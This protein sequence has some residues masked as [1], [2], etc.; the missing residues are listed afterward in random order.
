MFGEKKFPD[1]FGYPTPVDTP[2][3]TTC[4][5]L[6]IPANAAWWAIFTGLL[7]SIT[8][9]EAW[10]Q[11][12]GGM[13]KED[14]AIVALAIWQDA[15]ARAE[16]ETCELTVPAP[17]WDTYD[18]VDDEEPTAE[19]ETWYGELVPVASL[20]ADEDLTWREN[21]G[22]W[23][24]AGF[25]AYAGQIGAAIAFVPFARR[26]VLKFRG[27]PLGAIAEVF[28]D[29]VKLTALDT[30]SDEDR[31]MAIDV[32]LPDDDDEHEIWVAVGEDSPPGTTLQV[33][34]KELDPAEVYPTNLRYDADCD[35]IQQ[36]Y[37]GGSTWVRQDGQDP[38]HSPTF[39]FP[40]VTADDPKCQAA[41]NMALY[42]ENIID[43]TLSAISTG[44]DI[45]GLATTIMPIFIELGPFA[46]LFDVGLGL[47][48]GLIGLGVDVINMEFTPET[49]SALACIFFCNIEADGSVTEEDLGGIIAD[50]ADQLNPDVQIIMGLMFLLMGEVGLSN[51]GTIGDAAADCDDCACGWC[52]E[53]DIQDG[54]GHGL[55]YNFLL[56]FGSITSNGLEANTVGGQSILAV[57][58]SW[59]PTDQMDAFYF[60]Y[61]RSSPAN[62]GSS[63]WELR[64]GATVLR[65]GSLSTAIGDGSHFEDGFLGVTCDRI[66]INLDTAT[67]T[68]HSWV[69]LLR[70]SGSG[71]A[72]FDINNC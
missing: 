67:T 59:T 42:F 4:L 11:L 34:R 3:E 23:A 72:P 38:R 24:I 20:L 36:T 44:L 41:A 58:I 48:S 9:E 18:N 51:A 60:E 26:F 6:Q 16:T 14:A 54:S 43:T 70:F 57:E 68:P 64:N 50:I 28:I 15:M 12:E 33:V 55:T 71:D 53:P 8:T 1:N 63:Q 56:G 27:N 66:K 49:Y 5:T 30:A 47:A 39:Q 40:P 10:Q 29:G 13:R 46:I 22:I 69:N 35:C 62:G 7:F 21:L 17:Y 52:Y 32:Q 65:S 2:D 37:D 19:P 31:I 61:H 25:M 45:I